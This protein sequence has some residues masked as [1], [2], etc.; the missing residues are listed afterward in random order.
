MARREP[1]LPEPELAR[2]YSEIKPTLVGLKATDSI[3]AIGEALKP[4]LPAEADFLV[5]AQYVFR[6]L[7]SPDAGRTANQARQA[8]ASASGY[9]FQVIVKEKINGAGL[10][11]NIRALDASE[12]EPPIREFLTLLARRRCTQ[13]R[14]D[15]WP[16]ND[17]IVVGTASSGHPKALCIVSCKTSLRERAI[18][19]CFW[20]VATRDLG[21]RAAFATA[22]LDGE[23]GTCLKPTKSRQLL[24]SYF[25][26]VYS[27]SPSTQLCT[28]V[29]GAE[30]LADDL[31]RWGLD[32]LS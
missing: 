13:A 17:L 11:N 21:I 26:R 31:G 23:L 24:E 4:H 6:E 7:A 27:T 25:D 28:Q 10:P 22:D 32:L 14:L 12:I 30:H 1:I 2:V 5:D 8:W 19:S 18:E 3:R 15:V 20:A 16:D 29:V 9:L